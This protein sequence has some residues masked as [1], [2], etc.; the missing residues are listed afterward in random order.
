MIEV[1]ELESP[2]L[3]ELP[4]LMD[5]VL[6]PSSFN[7]DQILPSL[8]KIPT[9]LGDKFGTVK[10]QFSEYVDS[11]FDPKGLYSD[12]AAVGKLTDGA[13]ASQYFTDSVA[14]PVALD[15]LPKLDSLNV[16]NFVDGML[17]DSLKQIDMK[18]Q[19]FLL[20]DADLEIP[21]EEYLR[22]N[23]LSDTLLNR[24]LETFSI[25]KPEFAGWDSD[26]ITES[27]RNELPPV[28]E[29]EKEYQALSTRIVSLKDRDL[30]DSVRNLVSR[31][32]Y[33]IKDEVQDSLSVYLIAEK[34]KLK[35]NLF[36][37]GL[38]NAEE[39]AGDLSVTDF[40]GSLGVKVKQFYEVGVGPE[41]GVLGGDFS[42]IGAR[43]FARREVL[44]N[45]LFA[46]VENSYR[47][48]SGVP[49]DLERIEQLYSNWK[50]GASTLFKLSPS[51]STKLNFQTLLNP[52]YLKNTYSN[53]VDFRF[54]I[55]KLSKKQ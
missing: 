36:F 13:F 14:F 33:S 43:F 32:L 8:V 3:R 5:S 15:D 23:F 17:S 9:G 7:N 42:A 38:V 54:G 11:N 25:D 2:G 34:E 31:K 48:G 12:S 44:E 41:I 4:G 55:S 52:Q 51:G 49:A 45:K 30:V 39:Y 20:P 21:S 26:K 6:R 19:E 35:D 24:Y 16:R 40:S 27:I 28:P 47:K 22:E 10:A 1:S 29:F 18:L 53:L 50:I 46:V 37:E